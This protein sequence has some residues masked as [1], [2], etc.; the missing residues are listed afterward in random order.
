MVLAYYGSLVGARK[1]V[2]LFLNL[3]AHYRPAQK[4]AF[5]WPTLVPGGGEWRRSS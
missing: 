2:F 4:G 1:S 5:P 3:T